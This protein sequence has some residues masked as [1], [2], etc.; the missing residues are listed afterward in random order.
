MEFS[1]KKSLIIIY[2]VFCLA[3]IG[4]IIATL[5]FVPLFPVIVIALYILGIAMGYGAL[6]RVC[7]MIGVTIIIERGGIHF[8]KFFKKNTFF[9]WDIID[10]FTFTGSQCIMKVGEQFYYISRELENFEEFEHLMIDQLTLP[11]EQR[12]SN[13]PKLDKPES[14]GGI[15]DT[16]PPEEEAPVRPI[17]GGGEGFSESSD[18][19]EY[20][21]DID[22]EVITSERESL[23]KPKTVPKTVNEDNENIEEV[24]E[25]ILDPIMEVKMEDLLEGRVDKV[26]EI[27]EDIKPVKKYSDEEIIYKDEDSSEDD[28]F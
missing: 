18:E 10:D 24:S 26:L 21:S 9:P 12:G 4:I 23:I 25:E 8:F 28:I 17:M 11:V 1:Y 16:T 20:F 14:M 3:I 15:K 13:L 2:S 22:E 5:P 7:D 19:L 27:K 6:K